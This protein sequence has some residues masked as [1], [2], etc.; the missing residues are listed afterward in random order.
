MFS[1]DFVVHVCVSPASSSVSQNHVNPAVD[2]TQIPPGMLALDNMLYF[3]RHH[4]DAYIRVS[5]QRKYFPL[6]LY[7][8]QRRHEEISLSPHHLNFLPDLHPLSSLSCLKYLVHFRM[9]LLDKIC[10]RIVPLLF[11]K[12][13]SVNIDETIL[14][15]YPINANNDLV[16]FN[17]KLNTHL[18]RMA[19]KTQWCS[20]NSTFLHLTYVLMQIFFCL[21]I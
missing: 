7:S 19:F 16:L 10:T 9:L 11:F 5:M 20:D 21:F 8:V 17:S 18:F 4:Q 15:L 1:K 12:S 6:W 2:F 3:A 14:E 13:A